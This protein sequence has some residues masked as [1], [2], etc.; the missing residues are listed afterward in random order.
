ML[1]MNAPM[2]VESAFC[3]TSSA[4]IR[5]NDLGVAEL[6]AEAYAETMDVT[7]K[8]AITSMLDAMIESRASMESGVMW[9]MR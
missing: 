3:D 1:K 7:A 2:K 5:V 8:T 6:L 9:G 4:M